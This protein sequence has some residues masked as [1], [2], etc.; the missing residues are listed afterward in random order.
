MLDAM[1]TVAT[2]SLFDKQTGG[3]APKKEIYATDFRQWRVQLLLEYHQ[4]TVRILKDGRVFI[5][6]LFLG[7]LHRIYGATELF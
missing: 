4:G 5:F 1:K 7:V 3:Y 2:L 6:V